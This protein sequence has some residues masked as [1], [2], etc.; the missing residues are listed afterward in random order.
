MSW[1][2]LQRRWSRTLVAGLVLPACAW[3]LAAGVGAEAAEC[4]LGGTIH[5]DAPW[6]FS[7]KV[8]DGQWCIRTWPAGTEGKGLVYETGST[9][10]RVVYKTVQGPAGPGLAIIE[11]NAVPTDCRDFG[12]TSLLWLMFAS[13]A[14]LD[15]EGQKE[16]SRRAPTNSF[17]RRSPLATGGGV[18][19]LWITPVYDVVA[20]PMFAPQLKQEAI[21]F[22]SPNPPYLPIEMVYW[23]DGHWR[24]A[25]GPSGHDIVTYP[26]N[27]PY[28]KGFTNVLLR[29]TGFTNVE[30]LSLPTG[31]LYEEYKPITGL[32]RAVFEV[33]DRAL[34]NVT[35][36]KAG[37]SRTNLLPDYKGLIAIQDRRLVQAGEPTPPMDYAAYNGRWPG[38]EEVQRH[39]RLKL[40]R[41]S[42]AKRGP[43]I[44]IVFVAAALAPLAGWA[45]RLAWSR[46]KAKS[47]E[48]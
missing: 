2:L 18:V 45:A 22:R 3:V 43:A 42:M 5:K 31:F 16:E 13:S 29:A 24:V 17:Y 32:G 23:N 6:E 30:T 20:S 12:M 9:N 10:G 25:G 40:W 26:M 35:W 34:V 11:S 46:R 48:P 33:K 4:E 19:R 38:V 47:G 8:R 44:F 37:T 39:H 15:E 21:F 7:V 27:P 1:K 28:D 41:A 36:A 14:Y